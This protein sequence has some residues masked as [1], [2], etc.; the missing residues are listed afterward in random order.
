MKATPRHRFVT[1]LCASAL[2]A[3]AVGAAAIGAATPA[4]AGETTAP[5]GVVLEATDTSAI[6]TSPRF[7]SG[8]VGVLREGDSVEA[9]C[10]FGNA[11]QRWVKV[12]QAGEFGFVPVDALRAGSGSLPQ[13]CPSEV[14]TVQLV[15][16]SHTFRAGELN[17]ELPR[18]TCPARYPYLVATD[19]GYHDDVLDISKRSLPR[20][21]RVDA[22]AGIALVSGQIVWN[23]TYTAGYEGGTI[24][25]H[26]WVQQS[27]TLWAS[28]T[29]SQAV[30]RKG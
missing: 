25:N 3:T 15:A 12:Q 7:E 17:V 18:F 6:H 19:Y 13:T 29:S 1:A 16:F 21:I 10:A 2:A 9:F 28:C 30:A 26:P 8:I 11:G 22:P 14:E 20:G 24:S 4:H 27:A 23:G 5:D